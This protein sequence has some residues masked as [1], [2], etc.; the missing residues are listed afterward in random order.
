M[1]NQPESHGALLDALRKAWSR[2]ALRTTVMEQMQLALRSYQ[3]LLAGGELEQWIKHEWHYQNAKA[4]KHHKS[5]ASRPAGGSTYI[6]TALCIGA[7]RM[8]G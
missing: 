2:L 3:V 7:S 1:R 5:I 6:H 4:T 8:R